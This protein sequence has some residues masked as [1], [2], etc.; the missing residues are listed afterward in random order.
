MAVALRRSRVP[1][2]ERLMA[3]DTEISFAALA[4]RAAAWMSSA[5]ETSDH[6]GA[7]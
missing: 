3:L 6:R 2:G 7:C 4:T 5:D 1:W